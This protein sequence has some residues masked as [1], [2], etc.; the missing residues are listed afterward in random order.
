MMLTLNV[1]VAYSQFT[2]LREDAAHDHSLSAPRYLTPIMTVHEDGAI[3]FLVAREDGETPVHV[4][5]VSSEPPLAEDADDVVE[6][7]FTAT[8]STRLTGWDGSGAVHDLPLHD[9]TSYRIR[10]SVRG[11]DSAQS[12]APCDEY[13]VEIWPY[14]PR[15]A[16][17]RRAGSDWM[18][19]LAAEQ[20][21]T[22]GDARVH[23]AWVTAA[24]WPEPRLLKFVD[25]VAA[26]SGFASQAH[27]DA[28]AEGRRRMEENLR[29][30]SRRR[31]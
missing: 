30:A 11:S 31:R 5:L 26:G 15:P 20:A 13:T 23:Y 17:V 10:Y 16:R 24:G 14:P 27:A 22:A 3:E 6:L 21:K 8:R 29:R 12:E 7:S 18:R 25:G 19:T 9:G 4:H 2:M 1:E 28:D